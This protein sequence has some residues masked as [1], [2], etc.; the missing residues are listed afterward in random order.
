MKI[1]D[2]KIF[3][4]KKKSFLT[5]FFFIIC[6][7]FLINQSLEDFSKVES[8]ITKNYEIFFIIILI[9]ILNLNIVSYRFFFYLKKSLN[10]TGKFTN[11]SR[12]FF[13]TVVMNF[14][15][16]GSGHVL[17]AIQL[18]KEKISYTKFITTNYVI[19][20]LI[21][22]INL[23][24]FLFF[25]YFLS[26]EKII[27]TTLIVTLFIMYILL[28]PE[29]YSISSNFLRKNFNSK[30]KYNK[31][32]K[33]I[34]SYLIHHFLKKKNLLSFS[35]FTFIIFL[36][37]GII[38]FLIS[39][40]ILQTENILDIL[41]FFFIVFYLNKI[42]YVNNFIGVNELIAGLLAETLGYYFLQGALIQLVFRISI[43]LGCLFNYLLYFVL[44]LKK[45]K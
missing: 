43:Y 21:I 39:S 42:I 34:L 8:I 32:L 36:F 26:K 6:L 40:S 29:F 28:L 2:V 19:Y 4:K 17:R 44:K 31:I 9:S 25:F 11:W 35:F 22:F 37:E 41:Q 23:S 15:I 1:N 33:N 7:I 18:K 16:G 38:I 3:L 30:N 20:T 5:Y 13:Q 45:I 10:Y 14:M 24:L 12:L 27:L